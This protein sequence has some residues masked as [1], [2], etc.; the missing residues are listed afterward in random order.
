[1]YQ[2]YI[3]FLHST[4]K[5]AE[6]ILQLITDTTKAGAV[7]RARSKGL[8]YHIFPEDTPKSKL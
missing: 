4:D 8:S 7:L 1:M 2:C 5:V 6:G 3:I